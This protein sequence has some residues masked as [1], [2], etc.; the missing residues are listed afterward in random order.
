MMGS[1]GTNVLTVTPGVDA[2]LGA[3]VD[4]AGVLAGEIDSLAAPQLAVMVPAVAK[5]IARFEAVRLAAVRAADRANVAAS[6]GMAC[7]ADWM[8]CTTGEK[9]GKARG[10][11]EL[12]D[13]LAGLREVADALAKGDVSK[14]QADALSGAAGATSAEQRALLDDAKA[15]SVN[16]LER[17]VER[18]NREHQNPPPEVVPTVV[19]NPGRKGSV[20]AEVTLDALGSEYFMTALDAAHSRMSFAKGTSLAE[21]RA[22]G[23]VG[24][25]RFFLENHERLHHRLGRPHA[26]VIIPVATLQDPSGGGTATLASGTTVDGAAARQLACDAAI[27]RIITGPASEPLDVGRTTRSIPSAI[28]RQL[29]VEDR[30]CRWPGCQSPAWTCEGHHVRFWEAPDYGETKL[31]NLTLLC[32]FHHHLLHK[33]QRWRL[34]L[35]A[36]S[37][38]LDVYYRDRLV[39]TTVPPG[40]Q[41]TGPDAA[42]ARPAPTTHNDESSQPELFAVAGA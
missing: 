39:G 4:A 11:V 16:E 23:L 7:T 30:H 18:F 28:A 29:I 15:M 22:A 38:R 41:R 1:M 3:A 20:K 8:A 33:D 5:V 36:D 10:D 19:F 9:R 24:V 27:S 21:R 32:W 34:E 35:D 13:R 40:R 37:R 25:C 26:V 2:A 12:A 17:R 42:P 31:T 6:A 14:T